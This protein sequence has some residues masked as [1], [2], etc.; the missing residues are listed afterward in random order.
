MLNPLLTR[1]DVGLQLAA[2]LG[3]NSPGAWQF[4]EGRA[5]HGSRSHRGIAA[6]SDQRHPER[7]ERCDSRIGGTW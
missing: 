4:G 7:A 3:R 6:P 1:A 2:P 5:Q